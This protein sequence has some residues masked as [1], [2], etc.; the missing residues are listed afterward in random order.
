[1]PCANQAATEGE[2]ERG[3]EEARHGEGEEGGSKI[4]ADGVGRGRK[5]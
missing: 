1:M 4:E 3:R 5:M 2:K